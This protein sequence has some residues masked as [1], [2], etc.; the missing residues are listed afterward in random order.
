[1]LLAQLPL[2]LLLGLAGWG[3]NSALARQQALQAVA[4]AS[5]AQVALLDTVLRQALEMQG[6]VRGFVIVGR[7][8]FLQPYYAARASLPGEFAALLAQTAGSEERAHIE[9]ARALISRWVREVAE[10]EIAARRAQNVEAAQDLVQSGVGEALVGELRREVGAFRAEE[11]ARRAAAETELERQLGTLRLS[12]VLAALSALVG[13]LLTIWLAAGLLRRGLRELGGAAARIAAGAP[14]QLPL[15]ALRELRPLTAAFNRMAQELRLTQERERARSAELARLS[16]LGDLLQ[17]TRSLDEAGEV[18]QGALPRLLP[19]SSGALLLR[20]GEGL[21][22]LCRWGSPEAGEWAHEAGDCW[23]LRHGEPRSSAS[24]TL[25]PPCAGVGG[26]YTCWP[27]TA[28]GEALGLL[29]LRGTDEG[30]AKAALTRQLAMSLA[31]LSLREQLRELSLRDPLT[32]LGNRRLLEGVLAR[33]GPAALA[34]F[35]IDHFKRFNDSFGHDAGDLVLQALGRELGAV[36]P[37][38]ATAVRL[39][40]EEFCVL[41]PGE[42]APRAAELAEALRGAVQQLALN[43]AGEPLPPITLSAGIA[44]GRRAGLLRAADLAL[45]RAKQEGRNRVCVG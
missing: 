18:L 40:G 26:A 37:P 19:G 35:D 8:E 34:L 31:S 7:E 21:T 16:E 24:G 32:G 9:R 2:W 43:Y 22:A 36:T 4:Q 23:A 33:P 30:A 14:V 13:S 12:L 1:M 17:T 10:P 29:Q 15:P 38:G 20:R 5:Q 3:L 45:Y 41:L 44:A 39:G 27:L 28:R 6:G 11:A 42:D 25:F